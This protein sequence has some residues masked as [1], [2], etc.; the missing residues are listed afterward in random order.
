MKDE[1]ESLRLEPLNYNSYLKVPQLLDLQCELANPPH[2]DEMFFIVI[3]QTAELWFKELLHETSLLTLAFKKGEVSRVLKVLKRNIA[4][5]DLLRKQINL[6]S[7]LTPYEFAG[8]RDN[9][10][11][12]SGF[13]SI[14]FRQFEFAYGLRDSFYLKFFA[15]EPEKMESLKALQATPSIND[16]FLQCLN[17]AGFEIPSS[18]LSR[19]VTETYLGND[20]VSETL[21]KIFKQND[22]KNYH[23]VLLLEALADF[24]EKVILWRK[25][26][27][28]MVAR[29]IGTKKGTG[30][31]SGY[32]FLEKTEKSRFFPDIWKLRNKIGTTEY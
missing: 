32:D 9:L 19:D 28:T 8:F 3:H 23:W 14:Q 5:M 1:K 24:D 4:I 11:P 13:Q 27:T 16:L 20:E 22:S 29:T 7:T 2:H 12:A 25:Y 10:M 31:S 26:H 15:E 30:G 21:A 6:L 18:V 17:A